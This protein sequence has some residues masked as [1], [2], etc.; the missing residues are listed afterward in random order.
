ME[1]SSA[2]PFVTPRLF[3]R[4][5][6]E[7]PLYKDIA[8]DYENDKPVFRNGTPVFIEGL[9]A[10]MGWVWRALH[11]PRFTDETRSWNYGH[12][13]NRLIGAAW[14]RATKEAEAIRY[15]SE[16]LTR[17]PY[18]TGITDSKIEF[19]GGRLIIRC[20]VQTIY[21]EQGTEAEYNV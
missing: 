3:G 18:I 4:E 21:G 2:Y 1:V 10:V 11:T 20:T 17:L 7:L 19:D 14:N 12:E 6:A 9:E 15:V 5:R 16:C 13:L 8:W